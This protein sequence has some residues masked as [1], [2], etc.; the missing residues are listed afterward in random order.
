MTQHNEMANK[1]NKR[2]A[3][4]C[5]DRT[6]NELTNIWEDV[7]ILLRM[8]PCAFHGLCD[9]LRVKGGIGDTRH[10]LVEEQVA[11]Y[12]YIL[13]HS[14]KNREIQFSFHRSCETISRHFREVLNAIIQ[15]EE[16]FIK[17]LDG[18]EVPREI[19]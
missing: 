8:E 2:A 15:L 7:V 16:I 13:S 18:H 10:A 11:I 17:Q 14:V 5:L 19:F 9:L 3:R 4:T 12:P 1:R 6:L